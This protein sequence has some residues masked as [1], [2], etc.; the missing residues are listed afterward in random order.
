MTNFLRRHFWWWGP[1]SISALI[2][3]GG[4]WLGLLGYVLLPISASAAE[5]YGVVALC[6][7]MLVRDLG[8]ELSILMRNEALRLLPGFASALSR[9]VRVCMLPSMLLGALFSLGLWSFLPFVVAT[10][11]ATLAA[12]VQL[13]FAEAERPWSEKKSTVW[14][15]GNE[16]FSWLGLL[17]LVWPLAAFYYLPEVMVLGLLLC[18][19]A[20][21]WMSL[22]ER[23]TRCLH[24]RSPGSDTSVWQA[25]SLMM[26]LCVMGI[27]LMPAVG[28]DEAG[29]F[30]ISPV[31]IGAMVWAGNTTLNRFVPQQNAMLG[32]LWLAGWTRKQIFLYTLKSLFLALAAEYLFYLGALALIWLMDWLSAENS[33]ILLL[34]LLAYGVLNVWRGLESVLHGTRNNIFVEAWQRAIRRYFLP[35]FVPAGALIAC[36]VSGRFLTPYGIGSACALLAALAWWAWDNLRRFEAAELW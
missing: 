35:L 14:M 25:P 31:L 2:F 4:V 12:C 30:H 28:T 36:V 8:S 3:Q 16:A 34:T 1:G 15:W 17:A 13:P 24:Q 18:A 29:R 20:F 26:V 21:M 10:Y 33:L 32:R 23:L 9:G 7:L 22:P 19:A 5:R 27:L 11:A 6:S